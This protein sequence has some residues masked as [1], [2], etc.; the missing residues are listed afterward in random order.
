M[1][2]ESRLDRIEAWIRRKIDWPA[3]AG[4]FERRR[5]AKRRKRERKDKKK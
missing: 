4:Y 3:D 1:S 5:M 2:I